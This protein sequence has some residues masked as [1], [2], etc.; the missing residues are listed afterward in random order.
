[1]MPIIGGQATCFVLIIQNQEKVL[2]DGFHLKIESFEFIASLYPSTLDTPKFCFSQP[3]SYRSYNKIVV[4]NLKMVFHIY[5]TNSKCVN[6]QL[7]TTKLKI[8]N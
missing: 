8:E 2:L 6:K 1:M 7:T 3:I 4:L 5:I